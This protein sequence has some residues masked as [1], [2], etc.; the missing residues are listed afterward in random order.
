MNIACILTDIEGTTSSID[1][2]HSVLF[3][4]ARQK[5]D[6]FVNA[7]RDRPHI[8]AI[9]EQARQTA[10]KPDADLQATIA[11]LRGWIDEDKKVTALKDLQGHIW[12]HGYVSGDF[13]GHLYDDAAEFLS[14][15]SQSGIPLFIY[16]S[17]SVQAQQLLFGHSDAGDLRPLISGYFDTRVGHKRE[18]S[19]YTGIASMTGFPPANILFLS[20]IAEE[21]D[22]A[23]QAGMQTVQLVRDD[24]VVIGKHRT[25]RD[26]SEVLV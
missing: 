4:Y 8:Q 14:R 24:K 19:S 15:W 17:G 22:A 13:T 25:A 18:P 20:D 12:E 7:E 2:V 9:L 16:S 5:L 21:L 11:T 26:F 6:D 1:F 3:P 23:Q 10:G